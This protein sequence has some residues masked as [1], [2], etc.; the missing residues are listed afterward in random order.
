MKRWLELRNHR[1]G[2]LVAVLDSA[3]KKPDA[4][5]G[6]LLQLKQTAALGHMDFFANPGQGGADRRGLARFSDV[7]EVARQFV[8]ACTNRGGTRIAGRRGTLTAETCRTCKYD[9][10]QR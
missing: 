1:P 7:R 6:M 8:M 3:L 5:R 10:Q 9:S 4:S 2:V